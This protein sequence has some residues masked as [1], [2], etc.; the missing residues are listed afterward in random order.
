MGDSGNLDASFEAEFLVIYSIYILKEMV[1]NTA[2]FDLQ[3][4]AKAIATT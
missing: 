3:R 1:F 4:N 2:A